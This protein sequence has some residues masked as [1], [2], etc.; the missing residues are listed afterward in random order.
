MHLCLGLHALRRRHPDR[1]VASLLHVVLGA[2]MSS[3]LFQEV[4]ERRGL[5]YD[6][7]THVK[8]YHDTGALLVSAGVEPEKLLET[9]RVVIAQLARCTREPVG[10]KE[11]EQARKF[12][13]GQTQLALEETTEHMFWLGETAATHSRLQTFEEVAKEVQQVRREDLR[14][15]ARR[16]FQPQRFNLSVVGPLDRSVQTH[17][18]ALLDGKGIG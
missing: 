16:F 6:I 13:L 1:H 12:Y 18:Q 5:A 7:G 10:I 8:T 4:R 17:L 11:F 2:N 15:V 3:R 14:R 9:V